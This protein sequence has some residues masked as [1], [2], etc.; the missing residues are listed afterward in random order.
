MDNLPEDTERK[1]LDIG[2]AAKATAIVVILGWALSKGLAFY[3]SPLISTIAFIIGVTGISLWFTRS[4]YVFKDNPVNENEI[5][6]EET[7]VQSEI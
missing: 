6:D 1:V 7:E 3:M 4:G 2:N 5:K